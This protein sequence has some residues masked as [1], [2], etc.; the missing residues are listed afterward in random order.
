MRAFHEP[1]LARFGCRLLDR[2]SCSGPS[3]GLDHGVIDV[4][5]FPNAM[6][7]GCTGAARIDR[8]VLACVGF[9][10]ERKSGSLAIVGAL[11]VDLGVIHGMPSA[12]WKATRQTPATEE[13]LA[14]MEAS[15]AKN[16][17]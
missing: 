2:N 11:G 4:V 12:E 3:K 6:K 13:Q 5:L 15:V 10:A 17:H 1:G 14:R 7:E 8:D 16:A 9:A